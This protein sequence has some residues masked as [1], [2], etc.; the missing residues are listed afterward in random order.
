[1]LQRW[2]KVTCFINDKP[3]PFRVSVGKP[4]WYIL[5]PK[6]TTEA[7]PIGHADLF[8]VR[9]YLKLLPKLNAIALRR[10]DETT[11]LTYPYN[12]TD[13]KQRHIPFPLPTYLVNENITPLSRVTC[14]IMGD[15]LLF[16]KRGYRIQIEPLIES[17]NK[18]IK[19]PQRI[20]GLPKTFYTA[21]SIL[22]EELIKQDAEER[23]KTV[24]GKI[25][26][27]VAY[28]GGKLIGYTER[29]SGYNVTWEDNGVHHSVI[30]EPSLRLASAGICLS[31]TDRE[32][33]LSSAIAVMRG[34]GEDDYDDY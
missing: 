28:L 1:M 30:I 20:K 12:E 9:D 4:G 25:E 32:H 2:S 22:V 5:H 7:V 11:W 26:D 18:R 13:A 21:Y 24:I 23:K 16:E 3:Y 33:S 29:G 15:T 34:S 14:R 17:L 27:A 10:L 6:G 19:A 8:R 31:G